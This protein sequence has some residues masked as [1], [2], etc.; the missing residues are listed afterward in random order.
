MIGK[1]LSWTDIGKTILLPYRLHRHSNI[2]IKSE[3][4]PSLLPRFSFV[5][6]KTVNLVMLQGYCS[7]LQITKEMLKLISHNTRWQLRN[8][9]EAIYV[10]VLSRMTIRYLYL[11]CISI[12]ALRLWSECLRV[13]IHIINDFEFIMSRI[14]HFFDD[15]ENCTLYRLLNYASLVT[16][17]VKS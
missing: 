15:Q 5:I 8:V 17:L 2:M 16:Y 4:L 10:N 12:H 14:R 1:S 7:C 6:W 13:S 3:R 9:F 11:H